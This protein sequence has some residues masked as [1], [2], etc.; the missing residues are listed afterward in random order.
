MSDHAAQIKSMKL[1]TYIERIHNELAE[2]GKD[3]N[4]PLEA[5][6]LS[7]FDQLHY[8]GTDAVDHAISMLG[9]QSEAR[10]LEIGSGLGGPSR[11][12]AANTRAKV[13]ALELQPDQNTLAAELTERCGLSANVE[14]VAGDFLNHSWGDRLFSHI[15]SWLAI[16]HIPNRPR[17]L[18]ISRNILQQDGLYFAEDLY[19]RSAISQTESEELKAGLYATYLPDMDTYQKDF[20]Q[21]GFEIVQCDDMSDDWTQFTT[22]RLGSYRSAKDRHIRVQGESTFRAMEEFYDLVNRYFRSGKLGGVRILARKS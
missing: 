17:L 1:Y 4:A 21:A 6:E 10:V 2:I 19:S 20:T 16:Y 14:H 3:K 5:A 13:T 11:H 8:H 18:E 7:A 15:V 9:I 12:I 22:E